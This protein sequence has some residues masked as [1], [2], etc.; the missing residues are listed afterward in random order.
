MRTCELQYL[1]LRVDCLVELL[2]FCCHL[3]LIAVRPVGGAT[4][5]GNEYP[6]NKSQVYVSNWFTVGFP[7]YRFLL[8]S[9]FSSLFSHTKEKNDLITLVQCSMEIV[10]HLIKIVVMLAR[11]VMS[12]YVTLP[13]IANNVLDRNEIL[14]TIK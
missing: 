5:V 10:F 9:I 2:D 11:H 14:K 3:D 13:T 12:C 4:F 6:T 8:F 7:D 1:K